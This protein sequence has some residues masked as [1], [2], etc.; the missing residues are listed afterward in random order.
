MNAIPVTEETSH[1]DKSWLND[2]AC[3]NIPLI[4]VTEETSHDDKSPLKDDAA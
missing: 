3:W 2:D 4:R 1:K